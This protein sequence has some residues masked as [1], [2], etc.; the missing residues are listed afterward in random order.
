MSNSV[1]AKNANGT[2]NLHL[3]FQKSTM[4]KNIDKKEILNDVN[5]R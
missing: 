3:Y 2:N 4:A 5:F 1:A